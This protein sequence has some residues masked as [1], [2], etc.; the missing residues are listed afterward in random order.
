MATNMTTRDMRLTKKH[1]LGSPVF[2]CRLIVA[3]FYTCRLSFS[4]RLLTR[5]AL[6]VFWLSALSISEQFGTVANS[7]K[8][9]PKLGLFLDA[10][11]LSPA[12]QLSM[13][14]SNSSPP[15]FLESYLNFLKLDGN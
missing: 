12:Y 2:R 8:L 9:L 3:L 7:V 5:S 13:S 11:Q 6:A 10:R 14:L 15:L 4:S 1:G